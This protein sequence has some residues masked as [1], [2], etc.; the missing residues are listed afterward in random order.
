[1]KQKQKPG[2]AQCEAVYMAINDMARRKGLSLTELAKAADLDRTALRKS[3]QKL[4]TRVILPTTT[5][6]MAIMQAC[7]MDWFQW[8]EIIERYN[9]E[10]NK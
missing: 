1:M 5:T 6:L 7:N 3:K 10:F 4:D 2:R 8:A 9:K